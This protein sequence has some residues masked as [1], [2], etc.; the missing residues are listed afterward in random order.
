MNEWMNEWMFMQC[1]Q[2]KE[3]NNN[4]DDDDDDDVLLHSLI[5]ATTDK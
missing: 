1:K 4:N 5:K 2:R 3:L